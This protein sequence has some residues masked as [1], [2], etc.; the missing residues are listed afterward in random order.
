MMFLTPIPRG[1][2][3]HAATQRPQIQGFARCELRIFFLLK[4]GDD[5]DD[6]S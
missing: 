2:A 3:D 5:G 4:S 6:E 1:E